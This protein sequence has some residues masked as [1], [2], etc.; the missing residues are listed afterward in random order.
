MNAQYC[1]CS[2][3]KDINWSFDKHKNVQYSDCRIIFNNFTSLEKI[4]TIDNFL[5]LLFIVPCEFKYS[6]N[7]LIHRASQVSKCQTPLMAIPKILTSP[8][9]YQLNCNGFFFPMPWNVVLQLLYCEFYVF[10]RSV[11]FFLN[12]KIHNIVM[13]SCWPLIKNIQKLESLFLKIDKRMKKEV[14]EFE[15]S[16]INGRYS[17]NL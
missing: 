8:G 10:N 6:L 9:D 3:Y 16:R 12:T 11:D 7:S 15:I 13:H 14:S 5:S 1:E 2:S 17:Y 4:L